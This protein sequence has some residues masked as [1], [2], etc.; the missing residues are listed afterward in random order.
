MAG[1]QFRASIA[2]YD[3]TGS[4]DLGLVLEHVKLY[5]HALYLATLGLRASDYAADES[6]DEVL[7]QLADAAEQ[8]A[9]RADQLYRRQQAPPAPLEAA[10]PDNVTAFR[11][12]RA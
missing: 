6:S 1:R 11:P 8:Y 4:D 12:R 7:Y 2:Q 9:D 5:T 3:S 10:A